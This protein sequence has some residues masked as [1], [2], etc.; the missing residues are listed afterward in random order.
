[1]DDKAKVER[2]VEYLDKYMEGQI[3]QEQMTQALINLLA[4]DL[5]TVSA[6]REKNNGR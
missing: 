1:M 2:V 3:T 4:T 6:E 5:L